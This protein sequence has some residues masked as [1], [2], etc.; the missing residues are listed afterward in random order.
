[1]KKHNNPKI[2]PVCAFCEFLHTEESQGASA[3]L[4]CKYKKN[5]TPD[6]SCFRFR[7]DILKRK[8]NEALPPIALDPET[9]VLD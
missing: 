9:L 6:G 4:S 5:I 7:Y 3:I 1:M 8:P 2:D